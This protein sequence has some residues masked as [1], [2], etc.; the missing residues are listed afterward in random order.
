MNQNPFYVQPGND[1]GPGLMGLAGTIDKVGQRKK[2]EQ[3]EQEAKE[4]EQTMREEISGAIQSKDSDKI[5][6][7]AGKYP[8]L[9]TKIK[10]IMEMKLP[11]GSADAY[12]NAL[13]S[14]SVD[15]S[16]AP[17]ALENLR[18]QFAQD[19][20]DP[21]EQA[22][23]DEFKSL[24]ESDPETSQKNVEAE[25]ALLADKD[26]W[27]K[28]KDITTKKDTKE[29]GNIEDFKYYQTL[30]RENPEQARQ[31]ATQAGIIKSGV[32][33]RTTAIKEFE[34]GEKNP[35]FALQQ[36]AKEDAKNIKAIKDT[37]FKGAMS[38]R[39]EFLQQS[40]DYQK[41]RDSY[42]RVIGSTREPS[43]A[44]DLSL[45]FNYMKMLDPGSVVRESEFATA[46]AT[47][48]YGQRIQASVQ[49]V[50][51]GERLSPKMRAD[52]IEKASILLQGMQEQH[53]KREQN[54][55]NIALKNNLPIDEVVVDIK[56]PQKQES[57]K[58]STIYEDKEGDTATGP[59]GA[60]MIFRNGNWENL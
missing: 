47:G 12:K 8:E 31:F 53:S 49:K 59:G 20:I 58:T 7:V 38:L 9:G 55:S 60:K 32:N 37:S 48:S 4:K 5:R 42:T 40:K 1:F 39:K 41:V 23:L 33:D 25:F 27:A 2:A 57:Q 11:G 14:A 6:T 29:T 51:S 44:G 45:I 50:L 34:Y 16:Q 56:A 52:F 21:Q 22:K 13:F 19:G 36:K 43:P 17:Q 54:Y 15:F 10:D 35:K 18:S 26:L 24:L 28:Y 46:A 3:A 30:L